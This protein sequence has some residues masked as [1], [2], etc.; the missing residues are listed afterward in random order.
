MTRAWLVIG[1]QPSQPLVT[2]CLCTKRQAGAGQ[3]D[4]GGEHIKHMGGV[5]VLYCKHRQGGVFSACREKC[6]AVANMLSWL[7]KN[8][9][10][11]VS[12]LGENVRLIEPE[13]RLSPGRACAALACMSSSCRTHVTRK[14]PT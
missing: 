14:G 10:S 2:R 8:V 1:S 4:H 12:W 3:K 5:R 7:G 6:A 11:H 9:P 13:W